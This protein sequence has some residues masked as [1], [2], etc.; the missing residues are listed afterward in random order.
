[1]ANLKLS[2]SPVYVGISLTAD[3]Q[4]NHETYLIKSLIILLKSSKSTS[5]FSILEKDIVK[6]EELVT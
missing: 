4:E 6:A 1:M 2:R 5:L 3:V